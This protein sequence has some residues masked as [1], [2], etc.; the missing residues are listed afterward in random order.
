MQKS[1]QIKTE[2][3]KTAQYL[4]EDFTKDNCPMTY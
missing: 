4:Q 1:K 3:T 2:L